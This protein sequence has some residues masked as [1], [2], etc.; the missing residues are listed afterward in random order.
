LLDKVGAETAS[1]GLGEVRRLDI[2]CDIKCG[3]TLGKQ[4]MLSLARVGSTCDRRIYIARRTQDE[5]SGIVFSLRDQGTLFRIYDKSRQLGIGEPYTLIRLERQV[6]WKK[7]DR[8]KLAQWLKS[9]PDLAALWAERLMPWRGSLITEALKAVVTGATDG[10][11][12]LAD[13]RTMAGYLLLH[14]HSLNPPLAPRLVEALASPPVSYGATA[15]GDPGATALDA[16][17]IA[18]RTSG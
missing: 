3:V 14:E 8:P 1:F 17:M 13:A 15:I 6:R 7:A 11:I 10:A 5:I 2:A 18:L 9:P 16:C 12:P 4:I